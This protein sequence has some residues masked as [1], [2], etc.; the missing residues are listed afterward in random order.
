MLD[1]AFEGVVRGRAEATEKSLFQSPVL[2][3][4]IGSSKAGTFQYSGINH[5]DKSDG[6]VRQAVEVEGSHTD[7]E[8]HPKSAVSVF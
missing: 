6:G 2:R 1:L 3:W 5:R 8:G 4:R 7:L